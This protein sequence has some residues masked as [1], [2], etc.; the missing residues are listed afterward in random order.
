MSKSI[1]EILNDVL[2]QSGFLKRSQYFNSA[3]PDDIQMTALANRVLLEIS[4]FYAWSSYRVPFQ[5]D[6]IEGQ[7]VY[8]LPPDLNWIVGDSSWETDGSRKVDDHISDS[9]WYQYKF[10]SLTSGGVIRARIYGDTMEV[11][12]PFNG[13]KISFE[14]VSKYAVLASNGSVKEQFTSDT[15][16]FILNDQVL[17]LGIQAH[18]GQT[19]LLPQYQEWG[20]NYMKKM[21]AAVGR[22]GVRN[23]IGG[24]P[25]QTRRAPYTKTWVN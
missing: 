6:L 22:D 14:Y 1:L 5:I 12:E 18:W 13:G 17:A 9:E 25:Q 19:K 23:T 7:E 15:D 3:D 20:E 24:T 2:A 16:T 10:S 4:E 11:Q 21:N 8:T